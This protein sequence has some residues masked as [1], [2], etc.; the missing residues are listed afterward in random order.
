VNA[1]TV[2]LATSLAL[3]CATL[4]PSR[5]AGAQGAPVA[6]GKSA[7]EL[8]AACG[9]EF[10]GRATGVVRGEV[11]DADSRPV[12]S[13]AVTVRWS[14]APDVEIGA[15]RPGAAVRQETLG[16]LSDS[17]GHW[18]LCGAPLRTTLA[19]RAASDEGSDERTATLDETHRVESFDM[20]LHQAAVRSRMAH[21]SQTTALV[22]FTV[23][24]HDGNALGGVTIDLAP[25]NGSAQK[26]VTDSAGRAIIP[27]VE[28][29]RA[30]V[31]SL[32][33]GYRPGE[34][35]VPLDAGRNTVPLILDAARI[36]TLATVRVI[37]DR[38]MLLRHQEFE[39]RRSMHQTSVSITAEDI[40]SRNPADTWQM[41]TNVPSMRVNQYGAGGAPGVYAMSTREMP[42]VQ[43]KGGSG[44][45]SSPCWYS[46]M[47]DGVVLH[48]P[49]PDLS[50]VLPQPGDVHG[51]EIFAGLA[52]IPPQ[53]AGPVDDGNGNLKSKS[54]GLIAVWTK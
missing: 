20:S 25:N 2:R 44:G 36:P 23:Q 47:I 53:Y 39:M 5:I 6:S 18:H 31:S 40:A 7:A 24:D 21:A 28:P 30:K 42:V 14:M 12:G 48:D 50:Q 4:D 45:V 46:V 17:A 10:A 33:I 34:I 51:I 27:S 13:V 35:F 19:I 16:V 15:A 52:T 29:G 9:A 11:R 38:E 43:R 41:L 49:M 54:C 37:G 1:R 3:S 26:V 8:L 22:V 32:A